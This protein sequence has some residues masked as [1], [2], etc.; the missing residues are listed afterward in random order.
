[1]PRVQ[2]F[3]IIGSPI[4]LLLLLPI[5]IAKQGSIITGQKKSLVIQNAA[6]I[7]WYLL[8]RNKPADES[9][10]YFQAIDEIE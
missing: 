4:S 3:L 8:N 9:K 2:G 5:G 7:G 10:D 1:M 6:V